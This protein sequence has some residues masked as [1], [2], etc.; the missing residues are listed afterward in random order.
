MFST[1][2]K[3]ATVYILDKTSD[4]V[5]KIGYVENVTMPRPM[6]PT[7]NPALS[8]GTNMRTVVDVTARIDNE[9]KEFSV[10][11]DLSVHSYGDYTLSES[12][13]ALISEVDSIMQNSKNVLESVDQHQKTVKWCENVLKD[14]NPVYAREQERDSAIDS[15]THQVDSIQTTL[16]RLESV[17]LKINNESK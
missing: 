16:N 5:V 6:Y 9:Q 12:K 8:F 3:G 2:R 14:L 7:Y 17:L 4:P 15:L 13:E 11:S 10:P 1:L